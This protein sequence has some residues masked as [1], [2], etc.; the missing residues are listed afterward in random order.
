MEPYGNDVTPV[1]IR[2]FLF[3]LFQLLCCFKILIF[4]KEKNWIWIFYKNIMRNIQENPHMKLKSWNIHNQFR[5]T[6]ESR[7]IVTTVPYPSIL[8]VKLLRIT[9]DYNRINWQS[10]IMQRC[11]SKKLKI[12]TRDFYFE[13][14]REAER[15]RRAIGDLPKL[16]WER[17][18]LATV[19]T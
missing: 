2:P 12:S 7:P 4:F 16:R 15:R 9:C 14:R 10:A 3:Q 8:L 18:W 5:E 6:F 17:S 13:E 11:V 19:L 1:S